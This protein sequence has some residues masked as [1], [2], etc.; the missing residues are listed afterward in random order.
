MWQNNVMQDLGT[1]GGPSSY[2]FEINNAG[3]AVGYA[4]CAP[5]TY[6]S[7]AVL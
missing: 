5:D 3:Q 4:C 1:L 6:L 2:A 7:H